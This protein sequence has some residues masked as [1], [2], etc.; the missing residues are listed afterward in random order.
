MS[1]VV[2]DLINDHEFIVTLAR[3]ADGLISEAAI[4]KR[5]SFTD[6]VWASLGENDRL[7]EKIEL[8]KARRIR[9]GDTARERAQTH[10]AA[11][12]N[13][14]NQIMN[15]SSASA[16]NRIESAKELRVCADHRPEIAPTAA[17]ERFVI[18]INLGGGE[19]LTKSITPQ[20]HDDI[21]NAPQELLLASKRENDSNSTEY[22]TVDA[23]D[24]RL[25]TPWG[26]ITANKQ[27]DDG[28]GEP[29]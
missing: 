13:I 11:A 2:E 17:A 27:T 6:E 16:R 9:R 14:L 5:Y 7:V 29:L 20:P 12:P 1:D 25:P 19:I 10:F 21:N 8:E 22:N 15:D 18:S 28:G 24:D 23:E 4:R 3:F 26:L